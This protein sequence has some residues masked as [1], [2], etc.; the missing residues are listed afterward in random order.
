MAAAA[1]GFQSAA[2]LGPSPPREVELEEQ[3]RRMAAEN[4]M[5]REIVDAPNTAPKAARTEA[6]LKP[7]E[8]QKLFEIISNL[9]KRVEDLEKL[10]ARQAREIEELQKAKK[11]AEDDIEQIRLY[12]PKLIAEDRKRIAALEEGPD[13]SDNATAQSHITAL[14]DHM[15]AIGRKQVSFLEASRCLKLSKSRV[16]Q[17][18]AAIAL[19]ERF[20]IVHSETHKQKSL[21]RLR[22]YFDRNIA[23]QPPN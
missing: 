16:L 7:E 19:D 17:F 2:D 4:E 5:L 18:K 1:S 12:F 9:G 23:V 15:E 11:E 13:L 8:K 6:S 21:I 20:V 14:F 3:C 22:K 10:T